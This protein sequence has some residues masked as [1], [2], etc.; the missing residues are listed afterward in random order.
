MKPKYLPEFWSLEH[1]VQRYADESERIEYIH[2]L[3]KYIY[4]RLEIRADEGR[5][6]E[7]DLQSAGIGN[8]TK[9]S[10]QSNDNDDGHYDSDDTDS[11]LSQPGSHRSDQSLDILDINDD[12]N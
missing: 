10:L 8:L 5:V 4:F 9:D 7:G 11:L 12:F 2:S 6:D 3:K 1:N